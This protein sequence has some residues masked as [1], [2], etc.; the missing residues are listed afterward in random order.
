MHHTICTV[1][2][3]IPD[4]AGVP[5]GVLDGVPDG[6]VEVDIVIIMFEDI[7]VIIGGGST[8]GIAV[9]WNMW[10]QTIT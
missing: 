7:D 3:Y 2:W 5:D 9:I 6:V 10:Y 8:E 1:H 4:S